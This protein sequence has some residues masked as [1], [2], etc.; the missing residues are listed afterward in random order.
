MFQVA[1]VRGLLVVVQFGNAHN[2][3]L[4]LSGGVDTVVRTHQKLAAALCLK[5]AFWPA[6]REQFTGS[7]YELSVFP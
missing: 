3:I 2:R 6:E 4:H 1:V 5:I 7:S